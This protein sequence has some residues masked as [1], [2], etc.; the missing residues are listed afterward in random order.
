MNGILGAGE[1]MQVAWAY[2]NTKAYDNTNG[3]I[4]VLFAFWVFWRDRDRPAAGRLALF[5]LLAVSIVAGVVTSKTIFVDIDKLSPSLV[6]QA[7]FYAL[8]DLVP[9]VSAK[10]GSTQ[11]FPA[12]HGVV[13]FIYVGFFFFLA[14][15]RYF[16]IAVVIG[17]LNALP[18]MVV[19]A[20]WLSDTIVGGGMF[21]LA[22]LAWALATP[23][24]VWLEAVVA[25]GLRR[26]GLNRPS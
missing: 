8:Q 16:L 15:R 23:A 25:W 21:A 10:T 1:W 17:L 22:V 2:M 13:T 7:D 3:A 19:G 6:F 18:R 14:A 26:V 5:G 12:D 24:L 4:M 11:S 20:H 9:W